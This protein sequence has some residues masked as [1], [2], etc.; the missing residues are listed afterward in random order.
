MDY[1]PNPNR[2]R[3]IDLLG[4]SK[5]SELPKQKNIITY[6]LCAN[7]QR[8]LAGALRN[9]FFNTARRTWAQVFYVGPPLVAA[10]LIMDWAEKRNHYLNSKEGRLAIRG[11]NS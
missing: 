1:S 4:T 7:Q 6:E 2:P 3:G 8:P 9:A 10:Y 5:L 11:A